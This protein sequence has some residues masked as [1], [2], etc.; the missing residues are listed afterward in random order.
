M[1]NS[2]HHQA[3][4][5]LGTARDLPIAGAI[6]LFAA[7]GAAVLAPATSAAAG[8]R[9]KLERAAPSTAFVN[10]TSKARFRYEIAGQRKRD[11]VISAVRRG[12]GRTFRRW[13]RDGVA[14]HQVHRIRWNGTVRG[15]SKPARSGRYVFRV[16]ERGGRRLDRSNATGKSAIQLRRHRFPVPGRHRYGDGYGAG[17]GH[18]GQDIFAKCGRRL[19]AARAGRVQHVGRGPS[20]GHYVVIDGK[21]T[22]MDYVYM[23]MRRRI[24]VRKGQRVKTGQRI[25]RVGSSGNASGCHL[26][27]ELWSGPGWYQGGRAK[28]SVTKLMRR[29]DRFS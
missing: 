27:F 21:R 20:A 11:L 29:W 19:L 9:L 4:P 12:D 7:L 14:P 6:A 3:Q 13:R 18:K 24:Q 22:G 23:H 5:G 16:K 2:S 28:R 8:V 10:G 17:R 25:G 15:G 1:T 26:H